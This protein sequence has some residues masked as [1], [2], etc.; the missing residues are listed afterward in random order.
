MHVPYEVLGLVVL[1]EEGEAGGL[2]V[3]RSKAAELD[4]VPEAIIHPL[5]NLPE[6]KQLHCH[7]GLGFGGQLGTPMGKMTK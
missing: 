7:A 5:N 1:L 6:G 4:V 2:L 3:A